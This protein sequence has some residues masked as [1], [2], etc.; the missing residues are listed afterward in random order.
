MRSCRPS[1]INSGSPLFGRP[2]MALS[3]HSGWRGLLSTPRHMSLSLPSLDITHKTRC[4]TSRE[5]RACLLHLPLLPSCALGYSHFGNCVFHTTIPGS[6]E[7]D[8][9]ACFCENPRP[10]LKIPKQ[11]TKDHVDGGC[12]GSMLW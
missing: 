7:A 11:G 8:S 9:P 12:M 5:V 3:P 1:I 10:G 6:L 4:R 2:L